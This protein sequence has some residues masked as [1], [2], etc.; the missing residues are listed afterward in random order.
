MF[1]I[2]LRVENEDED[3]T[4]NIKETNKNINTLVDLM[5]ALKRDSKELRGA[6]FIVDDINML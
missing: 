6:I 2:N 3:R 5:S 1:Y 4:L